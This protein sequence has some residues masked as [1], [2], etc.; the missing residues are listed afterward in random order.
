M[1]SF[2]RWPAQQLG[3]GIVPLS[4]TGFG[5]DEVEV[6]NLEWKLYQEKT[7][8]IGSWNNAAQPVAAAQPVPAY[9]GDPFYHCFPV[10]GISREQVEAFCRW[11]SRTATTIFNQLNHH[12]DSTDVSYLR[13]EYRLPTEAEWEFAALSFSGQPFGTHCLRLPLR[14]NALAAAYFKNRSFS[15][16]SLEQIEQDIRK[17]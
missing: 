14:V 9:Y 11:R 4:N 16:N 5:I 1:P 12:P 3:P 13:L 2:A 17:R 8:T 10:V 15:Q 6:T 7:S